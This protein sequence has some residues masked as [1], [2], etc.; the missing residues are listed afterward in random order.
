MFAGTL[1]MASS[2]PVLGLQDCPV[3]L[4]DISAR[5]QEGLS[6]GCAAEAKHHLRTAVLQDNQS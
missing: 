5:I 2:G 4:P 3:M 1:I 6:A